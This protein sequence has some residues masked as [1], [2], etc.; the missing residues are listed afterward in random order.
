MN[1]NENLNENISSPESV[2]TVC[3][4]GTGC[5]RDEGEISRPESDA[6]IY[7]EKSGYIPVRIH[8]EISGDIRANQ[9]DLR[10]EYSSLTVRGV[11]ENDW[12]IPRD[13]GMQI[14]LAGPLN[15]DPDLIA[16]STEYSYG[17]Q[18]SKL[19]QIVG[20]SMSAL[21]LHGANNAVASGKRQF[22]F[23][24]H[25]RGAVECIMAAW[26][27]YTYG[28]DD[29]KKIPINIF[30]I[31]PVPGTGEWYGIMTQ[32]PPNVV[33]YVGIYAWDMNLP[34]DRPFNALV[35]RPNGFMTGTDN[36]V[37]FNDSWWPVN[38][39]K[40][41]ADKNQLTDPLL[42][43]QHPQPINYELYACRGRH[44]TVSGNSTSDS[45]YNADKVSSHVTASPNL[46]YKM[47]RAY[48]TKWGTEFIQKSAVEENVLSLRKRINTDHREFDLMG[49]GEIRTSVFAFR[50]Y[51]RRVSSIYGSNPS[52]TYY[53]DDV[54]GDPPYKMAYPVTK[55]RENAGWV[56]WKFL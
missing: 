53:M 8:A 37:T 35:P 47:A 56:K 6:N 42:P 21:A 11:G 52:N 34:S 28:D 50:P 24:G 25:S 13:W 16:Y 43:S 17:N 19:Q 5:T 40:Y 23:I 38:R 44:S 2:F 54:V 20:L 36:N 41:I 10:P 1:S 26:F 48:L 12:A 30:A 27:I 55:D 4:C 51:V 31:D 29:V 3:F 33:H 32:L 15:V 46:I 45:G 9:S 49:G 18:Y 39:W 7:S 14:D 22:N